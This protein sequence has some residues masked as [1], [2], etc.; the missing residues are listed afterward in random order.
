[1]RRRTEILFRVALIV[2]IKKKYKIVAALREEDEEEVKAE[3]KR[4]G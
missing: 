1:M 4:K 3:Q 2:A